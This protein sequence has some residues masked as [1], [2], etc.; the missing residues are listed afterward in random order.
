VPNCSTKDNCNT[1]AFTNAVN[2]QGLCG[3]NDWRLPTNED[4]RGLV[5][6]SDGKTKTLG[7]DESDYICTGSP[8]APTINATYFPNTQTSW[9]WSSLPNARN[10]N[11]AWVVNFYNGNSDYDYKYYYYVVRLVR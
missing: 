11:D 5:F 4:L 10:S 8:T 6:C 7:K 3:A 1:Y 9:F 2:K